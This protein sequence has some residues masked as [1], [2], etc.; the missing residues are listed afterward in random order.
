MDCRECQPELAGLL[1]NDQSAGNLVAVREHLKRCS[2]CQALFRELSEADLFFRQARDLDPDPRLWLRIQ[3]RLSDNPNE[4]VSRSALGW[5]QAVRQGLMAPS[6][7]VAGA[8]A[9]VLLLAISLTIGWLQQHSQR[10][11]QQRL[12]AITD[13]QADR[14]TDADL[15]PFSK[16]ALENLEANPFRQPD[17]ENSLNPFKAP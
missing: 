3:S 1:D 12:A 16:L 5:R 11:K 14:L 17:M 7:R 10:V 9:V 13:L 8:L 6:W 2:S 4:C 15:N